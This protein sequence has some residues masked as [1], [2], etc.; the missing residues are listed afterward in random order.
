MKDLSNFVPCKSD[1]AYDYS[2]YL[3]YI[4]NKKS[5]KH[6]TDTY[7]F[8]NV[9]TESDATYRNDF[10]IANSETLNE[11]TKK[12]YKLLNSIDNPS[13]PIP[14]RM[15]GLRLRFF[16][17]SEYNN[18]NLY[19][20]FSD[21][22]DPLYEPRDLS[23]LLLDKPF[24]YLHLVILLVNSLN[25]NI[26]ANTDSYLKYVNTYKNQLPDTLLAFRKPKDIICDPIFAKKCPNLYCDEKE[27]DIIKAICEYLISSVIFP[28]CL[29]KCHS[30]ILSETD[31]VISH[32]L[33]YKYY[34]HIA[35]QLI[36]ILFTQYLQPTSYKAAIRFGTFMLNN[37][38]SKFFS[39]AEPIDPIL[40]LSSGMTE[41]DGLLY[42]Y[43]KEMNKN[44]L[45]EATFE[46]LSNAFCV[47]YKKFLSYLFDNEE[48]CFTL[49][50]QNCN[51]KKN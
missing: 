12:M 51:P 43:Q 39:H 37:I 8:H 6:P 26:C 28:E 35:L 17:F 40:N 41:L 20:L 46:E 30:W 42:M 18:K 36:N 44:I 14:K 31:S 25:N 38:K 29:D 3:Q 24:D 16:F 13:E 48:S 33:S 1:L 32:L 9:K 23:S 2:Q 21:I 34:N 4:S 27:Y 5:L 50:S 45:D 7:S 11:Y 47:I 15:I 10:R 22:D 49:L 19:F